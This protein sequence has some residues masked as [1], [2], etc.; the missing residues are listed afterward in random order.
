[1]ARIDPGAICD[2]DLGSGS[3]AKVKALQGDRRR[4]APLSAIFLALG[5][6][7]H[8]NLRSSNHKLALR[9]TAS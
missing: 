9:S 3:A 8:R 4:N 6:I 7:S 1:M 2:Q 5:A